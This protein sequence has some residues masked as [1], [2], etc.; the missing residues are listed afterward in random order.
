[1]ERVARITPRL[2]RPR[3]RLSN[4]T[5]LWIQPQ[6][7]DQMMVSPLIKP[8]ATSE[9]PQPEQKEVQ[10]QLASLIMG[11]E[12]LS[13]LDVPVVIGYLMGAGQMTRAFVFIAQV[14]FSVP[15]LPKDQLRALL[16]FTWAYHPLPASV[17]L[18]VGLMVRGAQVKAMASIGDDVGP[19]LAEGWQLAERADASHD[20]AVFMFYMNTLTEVAKKD[21]RKAISN[22][23]WILKN[24]EHIEFGGEKLSTVLSGKAAGDLIWFVVQDIA[25]VE[26]LGL[27]IDTIAAMV[28]VEREKAFVEAFQ[29]AHDRADTAESC[30]LA[31][32]RP[33]LN[34]HDKDKSD[35]AWGP[36]HES[37]LQLE[38]DTVTLGLPVL[39]ATMVRVLVILEAE[40]L[41]DLDRAIGTAQAGFAEDGLPEDAKYL[42]ADA[43]GRQF[44][45]RKQYADAETW[46]KRALD[47]E[48]VAMAVYRFR[49]AIHYAEVI[50]HADSGRAIEAARLAVEIVQS[51]PTT[52]GPL[53]LVTACGELAVSYWLNDQVALALEVID[54]GASLLF[55][56]SEE[57]E[58]FRQL[59]AVMGHVT[60]YILSDTREGHPSRTLDGEECLKPYR[61][62]FL[63][64][65]PEL[66]DR[67]QRENKPTLC[68]LVSELARA[69][70]ADDLASKWAMHGMELARQEGHLMAQ[71]VM[72]TSA[73]AVL[74][75]QM[76]FRAAIDVARE[77]CAALYAT[78]SLEE[79][80]RSAFTTGLS[81]VDVL[82]R[83][84]NE[85]W[86]TVEQ[87]AV[88]QGLI[89][90][91]FHLVRTWVRDPD[92]AR[93]GAQE[94]IDTCHEV[95]ESAAFPEHWQNVAEI[96]EISF[97]NAVGRRELNQRSNEPGEL[98]QTSVQV[99]GY[100]ASSVLPDIGPELAYISHI[101]ALKYAAEVVSEDSGPYRQIITPAICDYWEHVAQTQG[102]S[103][104]TPQLV[105]GLVSEALEVPVDS[106]AKKVLQAMRMGL[107]MPLP[108]AARSAERWVNA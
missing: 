85:R 97:V 94:V 42:I 82:G 33:W 11:R 92:A 100:M 91:C 98:G 13:I 32:D 54:Q 68:A 106:R 89:P 46:L 67:Y 4:L 43:I 60:S 74:I 69:V 86:R 24:Y 6:F 38:R 45:Y 14:H 20:Y 5:G 81:A 2:D 18:G 15:E 50:G 39:W 26:C 70:N 56:Q 9:L 99:I 28:P 40:Y 61:S 8:L 93:Q 79:S 65:K 62:V 51:C 75:E 72:G 17:D 19:L 83:E 27:W 66:A 78:R 48:T 1:V 47:A 77:M 57:T 107:V 105:R 59:F 25:D 63:L 34:E 3:E 31:V 84:H 21:F 35:Q 102:F 90:I 10:L 30:L 101:I 44:V 37:Y 103:L 76:A 58:R 7:G 87:N 96:F 49:S 41:G 16:G 53:D 71:S 73:L 88:T 29:G 36:L 52:T 80:G 108:E 22:L 95:A 104:A 55:E 12:S 23:R 64:D